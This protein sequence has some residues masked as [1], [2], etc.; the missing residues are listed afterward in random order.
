MKIIKMDDSVHKVAKEKAK[1]TG[2]TLQ[3]YLAML[4]KSDNR[5][6]LKEI[7]QRHKK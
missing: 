2:M 5:E 3:G 1:A 4:V 6:V 7:I